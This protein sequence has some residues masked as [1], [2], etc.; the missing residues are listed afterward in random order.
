[1]KCNLNLPANSKKVKQLNWNLLAG[2]H[3]SSSTD[4]EFIRIESSFGY[5]K[6]HFKSR[7][8]LCEKILS[9]NFFKA[10]L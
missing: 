6:V 4:T 3:D 2:D 1:M 9:K 8:F 10:S 5:Q 7:F